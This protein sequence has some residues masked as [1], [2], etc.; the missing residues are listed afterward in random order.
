MS[1]HILLSTPFLYIDAV[2]W[3]LKNV[4]RSTGDLFAKNN[5]PPSEHWECGHVC[6]G[7]TGAQGSEKQ[8]PQL[9]QNELQMDTELWL[10]M[11]APGAP[12]LP[13]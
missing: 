2:R 8:K 5:V 3:K 7:A 12:A 4:G 13:V 11:W 6:T 1:C 9:Q 10:E